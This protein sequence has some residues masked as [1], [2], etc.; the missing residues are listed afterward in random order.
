MLD[1]KIVLII[2]QKKS[3]ILNNTSEMCHDDA[4]I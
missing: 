2:I 4:K 3:A 1:T